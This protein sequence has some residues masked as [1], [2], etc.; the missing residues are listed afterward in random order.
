ML[1]GGQKLRVAIARAIYGDPEVLVLDEATSALDY[2]TEK[3]II[4]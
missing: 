2:E 1:N 3:E 4:D